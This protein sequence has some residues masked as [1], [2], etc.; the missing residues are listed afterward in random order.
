MKHSLNITLCFGKY[1][2]LFNPL[3]FTAVYLPFKSQTS[4]NHIHLNSVTKGSIKCT[5]HEDV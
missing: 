4:S 3:Y 2:V 5:Y 1:N